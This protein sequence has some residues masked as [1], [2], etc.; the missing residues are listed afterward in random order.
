MPVGTLTRPRL[1]TPT[2]R[3]AD[4]G[5]ALGLTFTQEAPRRP[6]A[7]AAPGSLTT[8]PSCP[9]STA[10]AKKAAAASGSAVSSRA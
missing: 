2:I 6:A 4:V 1:F 7:Y 8:T 5:D 10:S 9:A 3:Y